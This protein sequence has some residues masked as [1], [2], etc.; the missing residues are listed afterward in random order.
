MCTKNNRTHM[1][2]RT[3]APFLYEGD[4]RSRILRLKYAN[5]RRIASELGRD[6][7]RHAIVH[8]LQ[9]DVVTW[10]PTTRRKLRR[11]GIDH[12]ELIA[13]HVA[14]HLRVPCRQLLV[15]AN[16]ESQTGQSRQVRM[17]QVRFRARRLTDGVCVLV[18]DDVVT[19]G[20]SM[21]AAR[22][23][24]RESGATKVHC[25]AVAITAPR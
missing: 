25:I 16:N 8:G 15:R 1:A 9:P 4:V 20:A 22:R 24:L 10:I 2:D 12:A 5:E 6:V 13:E 23:A 21:R 11:R 19:T 7:A 14:R 17:S 3:T 18:V